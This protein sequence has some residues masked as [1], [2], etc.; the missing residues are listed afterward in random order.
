MPETWP[1]FESFTVDDKGRIWVEKLTEN[2]DESE[3]VVLANS[4]ELIATFNWP[5]N[6]EVQEIKNGFFY[7][8]ETNEE[9]GLREVVKYGITLEE[10]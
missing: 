8:L 3:Y 1:V 9:T 2:R 5:S 4:G 6:K 10:K 7:T